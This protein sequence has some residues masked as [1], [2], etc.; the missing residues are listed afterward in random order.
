MR[1]IISQV[2]LPSIR[3]E[4]DRIPAVEVLLASPAC[5]S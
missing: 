2:L 5:E 1:A 4:I 3:E